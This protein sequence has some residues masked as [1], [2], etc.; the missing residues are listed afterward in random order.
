MT[1]P[2]APGYAIDPGNALDPDDE[3]VPHVT[4][5]P[6]TGRPYPAPTVPE[7][8]FVA[9]AGYLFNACAEATDGCRVEPDGTCAHDHPSWLRRL[10]VL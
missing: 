5:N 9:L 3:V 6:D 8:G 1:P 2:R 4:H 10:G 7:P